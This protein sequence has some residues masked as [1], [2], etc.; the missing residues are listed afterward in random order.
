MK[1]LLITDTSVLLNLLA[2]QCADQIISGSK[3]KFLVC[4]SVLKETLIL[5]DRE[6]QEVVSVDLSELFG[7]KLLQVVELETDEEYELLTDYSALMGKGGEGEAMCFALSESRSLP[8]AIDDERAV[9]RAKRRFPKITTLTTPAILQQWKNNSDISVVK[10]QE[11]LLHIQRW[12]NYYP[13]PNH[14][15]YK[16]WQSIITLSI[17]GNKK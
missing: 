12:A 5:R 10:M 1:S 2:T 16:W 4:K 7:K 8:V 13:G 3:W 14:P 11:I 6:T 17:Q 9:K 15:D